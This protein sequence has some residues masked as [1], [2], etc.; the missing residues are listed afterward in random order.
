[1]RGLRAN[2]PAR[3]GG[4]ESGMRLFRSLSVRHKRRIF[5]LAACGFLSA[6]G[7][8]SAPQQTEAQQRL[9][10]QL[11]WMDQQQ[12]RELPANSPSAI[13]S[14]NPPS[15]SAAKTPEPTLT[16][17]TNI[18][19]D[20]AN[21]PPAPVK[22]EAQVRIVATIGTV[23]IYDREVREAVYQHNDLFRM[24]PHERKA[25]EKQVYKE[26][27]RKIIERELLLDE[28]F[29]MLNQRKM[30]SQI[31][32]LR[33]AA[34]KEADM[35]IKGFKK[36]HQIPN[37][38]I[39]AELLQSQ[40]LTVAG[41]RRHFE[42]GFMMGVYLNDRVKP[43]TSII[44]P[45]ELRDYY[46]EH[47]EEFQKQDSVKWQNIFI[48]N[49][50]FPSKEEAKKH[51]EMLVKRAQTEE[52]AKLVE[53]DQGFSKTNGGF[54]YGEKRGEINPPDLEATIFSMKRGQVQ[55]VDFGSGFHIIRVA[56]RTMA[57]PRPFDEKVQNEV[58]RKLTKIVSDIE[59][60]RVIETLWR[61]SQ[62]QILVD[63]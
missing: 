6:C 43:K 57:G 51:A 18:T 17:V 29:S 46:D 37:D 7:C 25:K 2:S 24:L 22:G 13:R 30:D 4:R 11:D 32:Q 42:R 36:Q 34:A 14:Q 28:L 23:P 20:D 33:E 58:R 44:G 15:E 59:Y 12:G 21:Q 48:C 63:E 56:E 45:A 60:N 35:N 31:K 27:L 55:M 49:D 10:E 41:L 61:K 52:F 54:G 47:P 1:M 50:R 38:D 26:E 19:M 8:K 39:L 16:P 62:P 3:D 53:F 40:G 9:H 5:L